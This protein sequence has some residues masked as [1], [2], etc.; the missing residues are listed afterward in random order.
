M[1]PVFIWLILAVAAAEVVDEPWVEE[2]D[3]SDM[4]EDY[5]NVRRRR[6][7]HD[8]GPFEEHVRVKRCCEEPRSRRS[9]EYVRVPR[10]LHQYEVHEF[11]DE[12][13][14]ASPPYEEMLAASA[15]HYHKVYAPA[16]R[17]LKPDV[18]SANVAEAAKAAPV[19]EVVQPVQFVATPGVAVPLAPI[20][21]PVDTPVAVA[22]EPLIQAPK[23]LAEG[24]LFPAST[25]HHSK[26]A[27]GGEQ[28]GG[29]AHHGGH[30]SDHGGK[31]RPVEY[32]NHLLQNMD[33]CLVK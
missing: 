1:R 7:T 17:Y 31:V 13:E 23:Q 11:T 8:A 4:D 6:D 20:P 24:D 14:M 16:P 12:S 33:I 27:Y 2:E 32:F 3:I 25:G 18:I 22:S 26:H 5:Q 9:A 10:Q 21:V 30:Y 19:P 28:G 29:H 15:N